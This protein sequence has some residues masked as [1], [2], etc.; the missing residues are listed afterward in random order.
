MFNRFGL[1]A[2]CAALMLCAS[3]AYGADATAG[4]DYA[5]SYIFRG[6]AI[7]DRSVLQPYLEVTPEEFPLTLGVWGNFDAASG[8]SGEPK[9]GEFSEVDLYAAYELPLGIEWLSAS[10]G[11]NEYTYPT[12]DVDADRELSITAETND[13]LINPALGVYPGLDGAYAGEWYLEGALTHQQEL[14]EDLSGTIG[15]AT[16]V[17]FQG[18]HNDDELDDGFSFVRLG[19]ELSWRFLKA[20]VNYYFETNKD[21]VEVEEHWQGLVGAAWEF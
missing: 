1:A 11:Y 13:L 10:V 2:V 9:S 20:Q 8:S 5:T 19:G 18:V 21:V 16:G 3:A 17:I 12:G 4:L 15:A 14:Y 7:N 6:E